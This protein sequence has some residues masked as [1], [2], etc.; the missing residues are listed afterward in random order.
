MQWKK[1]HAVSRCLR[2]WQFCYSGIRLS[3]IPVREQSNLMLS[4]MAWKYCVSI[5]K[6][7]YR[8]MEW[9]PK[10]TYLVESLWTQ[11]SFTH[12]PSSYP[13]PVLANGMHAT[14]AFFYLSYCRYLQ[15]KTFNFDICKLSFTIFEKDK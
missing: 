3:D 4:A 5:L 6:P 1:A 10:E 7:F 13:L 15:K 14:V 11:L 9:A 12:P 2:F 8:C